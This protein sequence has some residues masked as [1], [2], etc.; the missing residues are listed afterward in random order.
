[1]SARMRS[2]PGANALLV[3][4]TALSQP[5]FAVEGKFPAVAVRKE[6]FTSGG[7]RISVKTFAPR[8]TERFPRCWC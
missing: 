4:M 3:A 5:G 2:W 1:M 8:G 6:A 7:R